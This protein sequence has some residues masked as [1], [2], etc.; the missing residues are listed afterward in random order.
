MTNMGGYQTTS[1]GSPKGPRAIEQAIRE[2]VEQLSYLPG[3]AA[4]AIKFIEIGKDPDAGPGD[5]E[6]IV[7]SDSSL[8]AKLLSLANSS[9]FAT[10]QQVTRL[11]QAINLLG[12]NNVRTLSISYCMAGLHSRLKISKEDLDRYWQASLCKGVA[13]RMFASARDKEFEDE[14]FMAGLFQDLAMPVMHATAPC[15]LLELLEDPNATTV[16]QIV[17]ERKQLGVDHTEVGRLLASRLE[18]PEQYVDAI[19]FH[20][21]P[22]C[23]NKFCKSDVLSE[24]IQ[25]ASFFPHLPEQWHADDVAALKALLSEKASDL[26]PDTDTFLED[27][28]KEFDTM[29]AFFQPGESPQMRLSE[30]MAEACQELA[31]ATTHMMGQMNSMMIEAAKM[32][33]VVHELAAEKEMLAGKQHRDSLTGVLNREGFK[34]QFERA[35]ALT[36]R[37]QTSCAVMYFDIDRFKSTNDTNGHKFGDCVLQEVCNRVKSELRSNDLFGRVGGD[38]FVI[39][40]DNVDENETR[41]LADRIVKAVRHGPYVEGNAAEQKTISLGVLY[42]PRG[43]VPADPD[44]M[45]HLAD[46]LMYVAKRSGMGQIRMRPYSADIAEDEFSKQADT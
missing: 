10:R 1:G 37:Y 5:Y 25:V 3:S 22:E 44:T 31:D 9:W 36:S 21:D 12:I 39:F 43:Q 45:V 13:A 19:A 40:A 38:E 30:M 17:G 35:I 29:F 34:E 23:L 14:A 20:H 11:L 32:G 4:V 27:V 26:F 16:S 2:Q 42:V 33:S 15:A 41:D 7:S 28:Q 6:R 46:K 24:A 8:S 18:L